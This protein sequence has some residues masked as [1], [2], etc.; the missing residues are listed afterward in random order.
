MY[1]VDP[2]GSPTA[3]KDAAT[4]PF[5][6]GDSVS[7]ELTFDAEGIRIWAARIG[8]TNR[9]HH[10]AAYA[11]TTRFGGLIASGGHVVALMLGVLAGYFADKGLNVGVEISCR[12]QSPIRAGETIRVQWRIVEVGSPSGSGSRRIEL[13]GN[14]VHR[15]GTVAV[16]ASAAAKFLAVA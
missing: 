12:F 14:A 13:Q 10:D 11:A 15:D 7:K 16:L 5:E 4:V 3:T 1:R 2:T 6:V 9:L 8:D